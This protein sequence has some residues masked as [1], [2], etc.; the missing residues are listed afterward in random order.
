MAERLGT[1]LQSGGLEQSINSG[2]LGG[3]G[4]FDGASLDLNF[5]ATK[6]V[7]PLVTFTRASSATYV[8]SDGLIKTATTN[9]VLRSEEFDTA[10]WVKSTVTVTTNSAASPSGLLTADLLTFTTTSGQIYQNVPTTAGTDYFFSVYLRV[11][12]GTFKLKISRT[13][14]VSWT[15][16]V[17]SDELTV[18]T[19]WQRFSLPFTPL[20]GETQS[21]LVIGDESK[22]GYNLPATGSVL[23]WGAQL[24]QSSTVGEYIPTTGTIN[25]APR[26]DHDPTTGESLGLLVEEQRTNLLLNTAT[27]L[28]QSVTVTAVA[29]TLSFYGSGTVTLS[30][31]STAGP[32]VGSGAFP[33][34]TTLTFT[35]TAGTLTLTVAGSVTSA[36]LEAGSFPTSYIPTTTA[37]VTRSADVASITGTNFS[38]WF[39]PNQGTFFLDWQVP[40]ASAAGNQR[41]I[42]F[43]TGPTGTVISGEGVIGSG[44]YYSPITRSPQSLATSGARVAAATSIIESAGTS[45]GDVA[46]STGA[47]SYYS[48]A[49]S[50][51]F[52]PGG[53]GTFVNYIKRI[54]YWPQR[55]PNS[56]LQA[57]T[58]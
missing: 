46:V 43:G 47:C 31:A 16:A 53:V 5:A 39:N 55:L 24:E 30:G 6:N 58:Q 57:I 15:T 1:Q 52:V 51:N 29:Y 12:S 45:N 9:L 8:G 40:V 19:D 50:V 25:S 17:V 4:L 26:F 35:P 3:G 27:L 38:S 14:V 22:T 10:N 37:T 11:T 49:T 36:Q 13:N 28:T 33:A 44:L 42:N 48:S 54:T 34:R 32:A 23:A 41:V 2:L 18:T 56:T 20:T 7:G 21:G